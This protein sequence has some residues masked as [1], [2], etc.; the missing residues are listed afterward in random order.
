MANRAEERWRMNHDLDLGRYAVHTDL[1]LE[2]KQMAEESS[3]GPIPGVHS[4][5]T[6]DEGIT[7]TRLTVENEAGSRAIGKVMGKYVTFEV[8]ELRTHD[9]ELG[10]RVATSF[11]QEFERFLQELGVAKDANVLI[12]GLGNWNVT[13][14]ALGPLVVENTMVTRQF[15]E[16]MPDQVAPGYRCVS[17]VAPRRARH[18][19]H[20]IQRDHPEHRGENEAGPH[21]C[22]RCARFPVAGPREYDDPNRGYGHPSRIRHRQ[23]AQGT[24]ER[25]TRCSRHRHRGSDGRLR[26]DSRKQRVRH[27]EG[28]F[29]AAGGRYRAVDGNAGSARG[30]GAAHA[31]Q[32]SAFAAQA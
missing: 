20:R 27:D 26:L 28:T 9:S 5:T 21:H 30:D 15:F 1:A 12:V 13:P 18:Y 2:A 22:H 4:E 6:E 16:L 14:D 19:R 24:H 3:G 29:Q 11:A 17:A 32:G 10:D 7:I 8:P 31:R 25:N 23:Q